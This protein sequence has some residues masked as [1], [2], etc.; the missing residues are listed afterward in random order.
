M[1]YDFKEI[2]EKWQKRWD[3]EK[4]YN[5][6]INPDKPKYYVLEMYPYPSGEI[7]MG[8][9][10]NYIIGDVVARYMNMQGYNVLHPIG[11]DSFGL[12]T[13]NAALERGI[14]PAK[15][16]KECI[17]KMKQQLVRL[18]ISYDWRREINTAD[19]LYYKWTQ[20]L[21]LKFYERGLA[22]RKKAEV[23][24]CPNCSTVL[25]KEQVID[26]FCER[27]SS[28]TTKKELEQWFFKITDYA[29][30]L[31]ED[32]KLL[33]KWPERVKIMQEN[34]IG[35]S[36]GVEIKFPLLPPLTGEITVFTTRPDTLFGVTSLMLAI[37]HPLV[38]EILN[39]VGED[40]PLGEFIKNIR[41]QSTLTRVT[42]EKLGMSTGFFARHPLSVNKTIPIW[43][44][45]Y[46]L[47]E[48]GTGAVMAVPAHDERDFEFAVKYSLPI[49]EVISPVGKE[50]EKLLSAYTEPGI[51]INSNKFNG[52]NSEEAKE[53]IA[54]ELERQGLGNRKI[55]YKIRDWCFSRQRYWGAPIPIIYC[56]KCGLVP[57]PEAELP[58]LLPE[59]IDFSPGW[60]AP[61]ARCKEFINTTCPNCGGQAV[62]EGD[63][64]DT[65]V[66]S[67]WYFLRFS[68]PQNKEE[69]FSPQNINYWLPVDQY[70]GGIEHATVHLVYARFFTKVMFD[71]GLIKFSE[72][73]TR[74]FTQ[75][76]I[77]KD[78]AKMSKSK[79]N[80][81]TPDTINDRFGVDASRMFI[82]FVGPP[83]QDAE[84]S[85]RGVEGASR[86]LRRVW[87]IITENLNIFKEKLSYTE[88]TLTP[89]GEK[90]LKKLHQTIKKVTEDIE[91]YFHFNTAIAA[92]MELVNEMYSYSA[93]PLNNEEK[94]VFKEAGENLIIMLSPFAPHITEELWHIIGKTTSVHLQTWPKWKEKFLK[95]EEFLL[96][97]QI[98]GKVRDRLILPVNATEEEIIERV[99]SQPKV[100]ALIQNKEIINTIYVPHKL[101]NIVVK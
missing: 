52:M 71:M 57:V 96:V 12:P 1:E 27:C 68:D 98:N 31:L 85:D 20:W 94:A 50:S 69:I 87:R 88:E 34:W 23:N 25:A 21:F 18:G 83:E 22:Y 47:P 44:A 53:A 54:D 90:L 78:G 35:K 6:E 95:E 19:P 58:V 16:N 46:V 59:N 101:I 36:K 77:Y 81:V 76:M 4:L 13:E 10:K 49:V 65:F 97:V 8:H 61:L 17:A 43:I 29:E 89:K 2:E 63:T 24:W 80:V 28:L 51:M 66:F 26:G 91:K 99:L 56:D 37:E 32:L 9:V 11:W 14:P 42:T 72:P 3:A 82:L 62:R 92:I 67:A 41:S 79:G 33:S 86:F 38:K 93:S 60:P 30:R 70:I 55:N 73:F 39:I 64:M 15:W 45:N 5:R 40:S 84:W 7:H 75:G 74:L 48:Y 100:V